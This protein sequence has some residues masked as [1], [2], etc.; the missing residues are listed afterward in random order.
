MKSWTDSQLIS[1]VE[2]ST[3]MKQVLEKLGFEPIGHYYRFFKKKIIELN[4][5]SNHWITVSPQNNL[6]KK[7][8]EDL[9]KTGTASSIKKRIIKEN[10]LAYQCSQCGIS[11]WRGNKIVLQLDHIDGCNTN[12][13]LENLRLICPNCHSQTD[14]FTGKNVKR[15]KVKH[16][17]EC[18]STIYK[19]SIRCRNCAA[20]EKN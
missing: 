2:G 1:A 4:I 9:I 19:T 7:S 5:S 15:N 14:T 3:N 16:T 11:D 17:C 18:G 6:I 20:K 12:N 10:L 13:S 8:T